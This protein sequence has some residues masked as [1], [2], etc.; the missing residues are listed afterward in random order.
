MPT[1]SKHFVTA[2]I[3]SH[4]GAMWLPEVVASL[5]KQRREIDQLIA[6][7]TGS[8]DSSVKLLKSA[9]I[10]T[11]VTDRETGFG[12]AI[13]EALAH[14][15]LRR[16]PEGCTEWLW[17][18]HDD[19]APAAHALGE[20][21]S[22]VDERPNVAMAG[23]K[24]RGWHDRNH[25]L[26]VGVS[27]AGNGARWTGLEYREQDQGQHDNI[28]EVLAVSTAGAL[29]RRDVFD[30]LG[31]FDPELSLFRDDVDLGWRMHIAGHS[32]IAVPSAIAFHAEAASNERR[33]I[34][35]AGTFL[36]RPLL[37]DRRHAAY[38]LLAN[39][40]WWLTPFLAIQLLGAS[41]FRAIGYLLAKLP[42]YALDEIAAVALLLLQ[43]QDLIR[44][45]RNRRKNRLVSSRVIARF[46][47]PRG[48][49]FQLAYERARNAISRSWQISTK[50]RGQLHSSTPSS[51]LDLNDEALEN[52]DIDLV[53]APSPLRWLADR[54][55][56]AA[57]LI[58]ALTTLIA[59]RSRLGSIVG[60]ALPTTPASAGELLSTYADS[61]H[62]VGLGSSANVPPWI[63][64]IG[65]TSL[66]LGAK[67]SLF[68][69]TLFISAVPLAL[70]G[71][72]SLARK[73][74]EL[75]F[76]ALGAA[77]LYA[78][79]PTSLAAI[80]SG[81]LGT[82]VLIVIGPWLVRSLF[83]LE[84]LENLS[85]RRTWWLALLL[86]IVCAFSP[87]TFMSLLL[88]QFILVILDVV[89]FNSKTNPL[90]KENFDRRNAR[91]I[92]IISAP[93][94]VCAP[95]SL[96]FIL[97]PSRILLDPGISLPGGDLSSLLLTNPG[98]IGAPPLWIITPITLIALIAAFVSRTARLG[99]VALFF[100]GFATILGSRQVAG[101]GTFTPD[102]LWV[103]SLMV[104]PTLV[105]LI[106]AVLMVDHYVPAISQAHIDYRHVLLGITSVISVLSLL[107]SVGWWISSA[108]SA[109]VQRQT[110]SAL[111][112][113]LSASAQTDD[114]FKT[115]VF[116]IENN[117]IRFFIA[118]DGDLKLGEP[119]VITGLTPQVN[120]AVN[121][122]VSGSG[123]A[124]SSVFAEYGIRYLFMSRPVN[125]DLVRT[126][127]GAG[128]FT[129]AA[130]TDEGISWKVPGALGHIS[131][132]SSTGFYSVLPSGDIG[133][134]GTL[135]SSGTIIITEKFD[136]RWKM[137]LNDQYLEVKETENGVPRFIAP[138]SGDF[139]IFH[140]AT[141]RRGWISLQ[142]ISFVSLIV[143]ALPARRR[144][145]EMREE[146]LA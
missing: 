126:I 31:G 105:A 57:T 101:H 145:R 104:V 42:G 76:L 40:S 117:K 143:L 15:K 87:L 78:F 127:D 94:I 63:A 120:R 26:E 73:F 122:L 68:I 107:L 55:I 25:L 24:L 130:S 37:L 116:S 32:V 138:E 19:C 66:L 106:A 22:A 64:L 139:V 125:E 134:R 20:L 79:S 121:D 28:N 86:T 84:Q 44:A 115:L 70:W 82:V 69:T 99:E 91:R 88:W 2:I 85:W 6:I 136:R 56:L 128:G 16:A 111:P 4:N 18:I 75:R 47:P 98:G 14:S 39:A 142:I 110:T 59:S 46:V 58:V 71:A 65:L 41:I 13:N 45:R 21:L 35:V 49:Q 38:V 29:I 9:G 119:D 48:S 80:N 34:D 74:T 137:L 108:P 109:P 100:I 131:F 62:T 97:H 36:H 132:L 96:E 30:E 7:D 51:A 89:A 77:L 135:S 17:L 12:A 43:P 124:S 23:P 140:D 33:Q 61:W 141:S 90:N 93:L 118:R 83:G 54:P 123:V 113:F 11:V 112:A 1:P 102:Q 50:S 5:A 95:W 146:E 67:A 129:R 60:G 8:E 114:R 72:Y 52:A 103:G 133:A 92:A 144:R 53:K 27:I 10:P 3:V 81:R